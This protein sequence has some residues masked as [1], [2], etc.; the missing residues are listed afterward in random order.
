[1][2]KIF[3]ET[4]SLSKAELFYYDTK[5]EKPVIICIHGMYGRA[6][7]WSDFIIHY[8]DRY[9]VIAPDLRG[10]GRSSKPDGYYT[11]DE[12]GEDIRELMEMLGIEHA[13]LVGHSM[14]GGI[15][16]YLAARYRNMV[17][18][19]AIL[20]KTAKGPEKHAP[21]L[22]SQV[23]EY[24]AFTKEWRETFDT[25][26]EALE[27][28]RMSS[29]SELETEYFVNSLYEDKSGYHFM[30]SK[31]ALAAYRANNYDWMDLL[32]LIT[33]KTLLIKSAG[34]GCVT[35]QDFMEMEACLKDAIVYTMSNTN[36]NVHLAEKEEFYQ[37][38]DQFLDSINKQ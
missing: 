12:M 3:R 4:A 11:I 17:K 18:A 16:G 23:K 31:Q 32:S 27:C 36:H 35:K 20:D 8:A 29:G 28:I 21:I 22:S 6:E 24:D 33:C 19:A 13:I 9:R 38:F 2:K 34:E 26:R 30:F 25:R 7:T 14:G 5:E 37:V 15:V 1:M 10:H